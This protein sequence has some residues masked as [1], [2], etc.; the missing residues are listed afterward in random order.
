[1]PV[2][3]QFLLPIA[4]ISLFALYLFIYFYLHC[5]S[6]LIVVG[7]SSGQINILKRTKFSFKPWL[8]IQVFSGLGPLREHAVLS[9]KDKKKLNREFSP[10]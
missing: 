9:N 1:M 7:L 10:I 8:Y 6:K 4:K 5:C 3:Y 2:G